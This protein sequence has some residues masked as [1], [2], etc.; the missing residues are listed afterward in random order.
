MGKK[1]CEIAASVT[2][3]DDPCPGQFK[4]L[5]IEYS[6]GYSTGATWV[7]ITNDL[8]LT[9]NLVQFKTMDECTTPPRGAVTADAL[10][11]GPFV[12]DACTGA[13]RGVVRATI[14]FP[15]FFT[16]VG[17]QFS[18]S[19]GQRCEKKQE[20]KKNTKR[21]TAIAIKKRDEKNRGIQ[22]AWKSGRS[23]WVP[24]SPRIRTCG[25]EKRCTPL[26]PFFI[27][28]FFSF[29]LSSPSPSFVSLGLGLQP[30]RQHHVGRHVLCGVR[31]AVFQ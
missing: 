27:F 11:F 1:T 12:T 30:K 2:N 4:H 6:C 24:F 20:Q 31:P 29:F 18:I 23:A 14:T 15:F 13:R 3:F 25:S 9:E 16:A 8:L 22:Q 17:G 21:R 19:A 10:T 26:T 28:F 5:A 7:E